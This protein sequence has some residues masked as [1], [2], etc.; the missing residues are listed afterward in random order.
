MTP[1]LLVVPAVVVD[2][3]DYEFT[4]WGH[5]S[6]ARYREQ[7]HRDAALDWVKYGAAEVLLC[8]HSLFG[9]KDHFKWINQIQWK[10]V[11]VDEY[12]TFKSERSELFKNLKKLKQTSQ[13]KIIGLTGTPMQ[14]RHEELFNLIDAISPGY[15]GVR[16]EFNKQVSK[17]IMLGR[18]ANAPATDTERGEKKQ[19]ELVDKLRPMYLQRLK[20]VVLK[21]E[22]PEKF[23]KVVFCELSELQKEVYARLLDSPD[24]ILLRGANAP[25]DCGINKNYF[26]DYKRLKTTE[27][28]IDYVRKHSF[29]K[30]S[31][32]CY[33]TPVPYRGGKILKDAVL[34][35]CQHPDGCV[36]DEKDGVTKCP[37]CIFLPALMKLY[38]LSSHVSLLQVDKKEKSE[39][40]TKQEAFAKV[41]FKKVIKK[42]PGGDIYRNNSCWDDHFA[43]SG[44][45]QEL[46]KLL[47]YIASKK[48]RVLLFSYSTQT[49]D[50][51][52]NYLKGNESYKFL[53]I[54]GQT[55]AKD[56]Q[57]LVNDFQTDS[58]YFVM[59]LSTRAAGV[60]LNLTAAN[61]VIIFD[62]EWNPA[63][64]SQAQDRSFRI[65]QKRD[66]TVYRL[67]AQ[68]TIDE[69]KYLR[70][71]YKLQLKEETFRDSDESM[72]KCSLP[73][74]FKGVE[75]D[76]DRKGELFGMEN[77]LSF[78]KD[79]S[80]LEKMW[81]QSSSLAKDSSAVKSVEKKV[82]DA[83]ELAKVLQTGDTGKLNQQSEW[84]LVRVEIEKQSSRMQDHGMYLS[85]AKYVDDPDKHLDGEA[86]QINE[87]ADKV[88]DPPAMSQDPVAISQVFEESQPV[89][90]AA[91]LPTLEDSSEDEAPTPVITKKRTASTSKTASSSQKKFRTNSSL[92][93]GKRNFSLCGIPVLDMKKKKTTFGKADFFIPKKKK[94]K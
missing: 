83:T 63:L 78:Q 75:K 12:H 76:K 27:E 80:F 49:L 6:V 62:C 47:T 39:S 71:I 23:E 52:E 30:R 57:G 40:R 31:T 19:K 50:V 91:T 86:R 35:K 8:P 1:V 53:R 79:G 24:Y 20:T 43:M 77:L 9:S 64:D 7:Q 88:D 4:L 2:N 37:T 46:H 56:R 14:N 60:G 44:K 90:A 25:C 51:I 70:Q 67:V 54:D 84:E 69:L 11:V 58:S 68:G 10:I 16:K 32:C 72:P 17:P 38:Q 61:N 73:K 92:P 28:K 59:L 89:T 41:A 55:P 65:G 74:S 22:M 66:V 85:K 29:V 3:W 81:G 33:K 36:C 5:F 34:W 45:M 15:L 42:L 18:A 48:G 94:T 13:C 93:A 21:D 82:H 87:F 26:A